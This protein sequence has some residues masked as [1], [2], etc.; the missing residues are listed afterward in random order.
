MKTLKTNRQLLTPRNDSLNFQ[1]VDGSFWFM[2]GKLVNWNIKAIYFNVSVFSSFTRQKQWRQY[3]CYFIWREIFNHRF[4]CLASQY[5][6]RPW[7]RENAYSEIWIV[8]REAVVFTS[9]FYKPQCFLKHANCSP[10]FLG[11]CFSSFITVLSLLV[12]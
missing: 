8:Q 9:L 1:F 5:F 6:K 7:I 4:C 2:G 3:I 10:L 11:V 12:K